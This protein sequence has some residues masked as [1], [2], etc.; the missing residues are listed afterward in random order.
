MHRLLSFVP[1]KVRTAL[2]VVLAANLDLAKGCEES[3]RRARELIRHNYRNHANDYLKPLANPFKP[4][5]PESLGD[6]PRT[7]PMHQI[8]P[9]YVSKAGMSEDRHMSLGEWVNEALF[10]L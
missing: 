8:E 4:P 1:S 2:Y 3:F 9:R 5:M 7:L 10:A 6:V